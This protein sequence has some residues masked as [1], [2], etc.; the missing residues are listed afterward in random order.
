VTSGVDSAEREAFVDMFRATP[1]LCEVAVIG[2]AT[3]TAL[4]RLPA[5]MFNRVLDLTSTEQLE[6]IAD[7]YGELPWWVSDSHSLGPELE[8]RSFT[9][10]YSWMTFTRGVEPGEGQSDLRVTQIGPDR[11]DDYA[12][13]VTASFELPEWSRPLSANVVGR[14]GWSCYVAYDGDEPAGAGALFVHG[15]VGWIGFGATLPGYRGRGAQSAIFRARIDEARAQGC[16]TVVTETGEL[17]EGRPSNSYRNI[18]RAG[19]AEAG[20]RPNYRAP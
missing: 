4:R 12:G 18:L 3:C 8:Q 19:F 11:A 2:G 9:R 16:S 13:I 15:R 20:I 17:E 6:E 1:D 5:R 10:D 7:F 14:P